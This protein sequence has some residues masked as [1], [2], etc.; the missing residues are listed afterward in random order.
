M[1]DCLAPLTYVPE[2]VSPEPTAYWYT[3]KTYIERMQSNIPDNAIHFYG[4][5]NMEALCVADAHPQCVNLGIGG[6]SLRALMNRIQLSAIHRAGACVI[7]SGLCDLANTGYYPSAQNAADAVIYM[8]NVL[9]QSMSGKWVVCKLLPVAD[10]SPVANATINT[11]NTYL[12]TKFG[13]RANT[14]LVDASEALAPSGQLLY[15]IGDGIHLSGEGYDRVK[16]RIS[17]ALTALGV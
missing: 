15:H 13:S 9:E 10:P 11:V 16:P 14:A 4:D 2:L 3:R 12:Q 17:A 7:M 5:S 1:M 6:E 8:Y